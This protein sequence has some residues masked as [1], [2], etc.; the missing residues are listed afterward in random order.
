M[1]RIVG[2]KVWALL[3]VLAVV[4]ALVGCEEAGLTEDDALPDDTDVPGDELPGDDLPAPVPTERLVIEGTVGAIANT[5][6]MTYAELPAE[7]M[8]SRRVR[9]LDADGDPRRLGTIGSGTFSFDIETPSEAEQ[10]TI[11]SLLM[12]LGFTA[13]DVQVSDTEARV[14][15]ARLDVRAPQSGEVN[16]LILVDPDV[17]V[18]EATTWVW[19]FWADRPVTISGST[20]ASE[21]FDEISFDEFVLGA[22]W[23]VIGASYRSTTNAITFSTVSPPEEGLVWTVVEENADVAVEEGGGEGDGGA[24]AEPLLLSEIPVAVPLSSPFLQGDEFLTIKD[25]EFSAKSV[26]SGGTLDLEQGEIAEDLFSLTVPVPPAAALS[27]VTDYLGDSDES[28]YAV[29]AAGVLFLEVEIVVEDEDPEPDFPVPYLLRRHGESSIDGSYHRY[30]Y[31]TEEVEITGQTA[32]GTFGDDETGLTLSA[33]WNLVVADPDVEMP[34]DPS[35]STMKSVGAI[36]AAG[37][38]AIEQMIQDRPGD[39]Q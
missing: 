20:T 23:N 38:I 5:T 8:D 24:Q 14:Q 7:Y 3:G 28:S 25:L 11:V 13:E 30:I 34:T 39:A 2:R 32:Q 10:I 19:Y 27:S 22:G 17:E 1:T 21:E 9:L 12:G 37:W 4:L 16:D 36:E 29:S 6:E 18:G 35:S 26:V 15:V 31:V 33:G